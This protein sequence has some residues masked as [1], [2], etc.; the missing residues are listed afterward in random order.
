M[1]RTV[2]T[3]EPEASN[4]KAG[5]GWWAKLAR[6][7]V[8][9]AFAAALS[10]ASYHAVC[11]GFWS[12]DDMGFFMLTQKTL[13]AGHP[14]Y[15]ETY[16]LYGPAYYAW[17]QF[18]RAVTRQPL[19]HDT[20]LLFTTVALVAIPLLLAGYV[21]RLARNLFLSVFTCFAVFDVL[22]VNLKSEPGHPQELC[23]LLLGDMLR[24]G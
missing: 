5:G 24:T 13:A 15:D 18:L 17:Q 7:L 23:A 14:L 6:S 3:A 12:Y 22:L 21:S 9:A 2:N 19:T 4:G 8:M 20:T 10:V 1:G 16:T 11:G